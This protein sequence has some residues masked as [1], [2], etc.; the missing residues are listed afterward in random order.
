MG[1]KKF[2]D[3]IKGTTKKLLLMI[4]QNVLENK[5]KF[6]R[7]VDILS[8]CVVC[9]RQYDKESKSYFNRNKIRIKLNY[10]SKI[11]YIINISSLISARHVKSKIPEEYFDCD[12]E[13]INIISP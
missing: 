13:I 4:L 12:I 7:C 1:L 6:K 5:N 8:V 2:V 10:S 3:T 11:L 9:S